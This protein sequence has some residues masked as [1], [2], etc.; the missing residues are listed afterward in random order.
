MG[1]GRGSTGVSVR[2]VKVARGI[3]EGSVRA[4]GLS[5]EPCGRDARAAAVQDAGKHSSSGSG[6]MLMIGE[7]VFLAMNQMRSAARAIGTGSAPGARGE[8]MTGRRRA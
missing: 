8:L 7:R 1:R 4:R 3:S 5:L 2:G 6:L